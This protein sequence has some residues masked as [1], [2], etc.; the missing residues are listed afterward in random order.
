MIQIQ[1]GLVSYAV[2]RPAGRKVVHCKKTFL[3]GQ[4][5]S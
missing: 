1:P 4:F 2:N 5:K 3:I